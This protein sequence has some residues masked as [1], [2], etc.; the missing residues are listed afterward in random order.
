MKKEL[1][2]TRR[3]SLSHRSLIFVSSVLFFCTLEHLQEDV[4]EVVAIAEHL[5]ENH[6]SG[7]VGQHVN[8]YEVSI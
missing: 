4:D 7:Q 5:H 3:Q 6:S 2:K 8:I 1:Q